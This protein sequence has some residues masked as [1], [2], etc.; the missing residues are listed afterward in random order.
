MPEGQYASLPMASGP[1]SRAG[2]GR[3]GGTCPAS[4]NAGCPCARHPISTW[5]RRASPRA[6]PRSSAPGL[7]CRSCISA[8]TRRACWCGRGCWGRSR[9]SPGLF[10]WTA[11]RLKFFGSDRG[12]MM[13][14]AAGTDAESRP[15]SAVWSLV[16]ESGD[17]PVIP[18]LPALAAI[19]AFADGRITEAGARACVGVLDLDTIE[20]EFA[21]YRSRPRL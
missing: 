10:R 12:G 15:V 8:C 9:P 2:A 16:A 11:E 19:R 21:P 5:C 13:V 1:S 17:G 3:S 18:T 14:V 4:G 6:T 7:S 20:R